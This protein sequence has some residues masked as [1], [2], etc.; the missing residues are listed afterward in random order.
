[1]H[2]GNPAD[3]ETVLPFVS[4]PQNLLGDGSDYDPATAPWYLSTA[5]TVVTTNTHVAPNGRLEADS[6]TVT[7]HALPAD[8]L[9][10]NSIPGSVLTSKEVRFR[11]YL[12]KDAAYLSPTCQSRISLAD[13]P[14]TGIT[15]ELVVTFDMGATP[16]V[17]GLF[18]STTGGP[19]YTADDVTLTEVSNDWVMVELRV[20][21]YSGTSQRVY[22]QH[23]GS[24]GASR[25]AT[26]DLIYWNSEITTI[27]PLDPV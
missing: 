22:L 16:A 8:G 6:V 13:N 18:G 26:Y 17:V 25:G 3:W 11:F 12:K 24:Q 4:G 1:M 14:Y 5:G 15:E 10:Y 7:S 20:F 19:G 27:D 23:R 9:G 2:I 21:D